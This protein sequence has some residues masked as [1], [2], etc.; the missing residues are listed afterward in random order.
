MKKRIIC[1]MALLGLLAGTSFATMEMQ[2]VTVEKRDRPEVP[3]D[4][5]NTCEEAIVIDCDY[6]PAVYTLTAGGVQWFEYVG[7]GVGLEIAT[8]FEATPDLDTDLYIYDEC[9]GT[10]LFYRDG[11]GNCA[12]GNGWQTYMECSDMLFDLGEDYFIMIA[13]YYGNAGDFTIEFTCCEAPEEFVC[14]DGLIWHVDDYPTPGDY[15]GDYLN[16]INCDQAKCGEILDSGD[17]DW[18]WFSLDEETNVIF[19]V[20]GDDTFGMPPFGFGLDPAIEIYDMNCVPV[21]CYDDDGGEGYDSHLECCLQPGYY[22][23]EVRTDWSAPGPYI[24]AMDCEIC[25]DEDNDCTNPD[26]LTTDLDYMNYMG[27][28]NAGSMNLNL[29]DWCNFTDVS[30]WHGTYPCVPATPMDAGEYWFSFFL[31]SDGCIGLAYC[32]L[33]GGD[34][35]VDPMA[36]GGP[37]IDGSTY[38]WTGGDPPCADINSSTGLF[39]FEYDSAPDYYQT[40]WVDSPISICD[41]VS[42]CWWYEDDC[43]EANELAADFTLGQNYPNPFNPATTIDFTVPEAGLTSLKVYNLNGEV[44]ATLVNGMMERG[45]QS[46]TFD[47]SNLSSG[48]YFYTLETA[49]LSSTKKMVLAK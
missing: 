47:A 13:D 15:C 30:G 35:A 4:R 16:D 29:C 37:C 36:W 12:W 46:V 19:D 5:D 20:Y 27:Y 34:P 23:V 45:E 18:F 42:I 39:F 21:G 40:F 22:M 11:D 48:V 33:P 28:D 49:G 7:E 32:F 44:V 8:C 24:I 1:S 25:C 10:L 2:S 3:V 14:P 43:V 41:Q 31:P 38:L 26:V 9:G 6:G 17:S